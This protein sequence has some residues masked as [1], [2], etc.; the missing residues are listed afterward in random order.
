LPSLTRA[1]MAVVISRAAAIAGCAAVLVSAA[2]GGAGAAPSARSALPFSTAS[3]TVVQPQPPAGSCHA[4]GSGEFSGPDLRCTPGARDPAVKQ[5]TIDT[6]I[7]KKGYSATV[8]PP[9]RITRPE[10]AASLQAYGDTPP[11]TYEYD[12]LISLELGGARNDPR[13]LWP[14]PGNIPNPKDRL[15]NRLH[16]DVCD[17]K[18]TLLAA[19]REIAKHWVAT[20]HK[21]FG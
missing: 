8:R 19:Q 3:A 9:V 10:K 21:L 2:A 7:C 11:G 13:N 16:R 14:E 4:T 18:I 15:E 17:H 5:S 1:M 12:H 6:T 20:Y